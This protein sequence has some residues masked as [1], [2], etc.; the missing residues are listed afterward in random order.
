MKI[1]QIIN[2]LT[3]GGAQI[4]LLDL[5]VY[6]KKLGHDPVV[7]AFRDGPVGDKLRENGIETII[8]GE[9]GLDVI[10]LA[11]LCREIKN[12]A[13]DLIHS[14]LFRASLWARIAVKITGKRTLVT[15]IHG[16]E[17]DSYHFMEKKIYF[18]S[19]FV[20]FPSNY[21]ANWYKAEIVPLPS[22]KYGIIYPGTNVKAYPTQ[23][24]NSK[25][26][27]I[28]SLSRL[29][30]V[31]GIDTLLEAVHILALKLDNFEIIIGGD[32]KEKNRLEEMAQTLGISKLVTFLG[33]V[34]SPS[35]FLNEIDIFAAPSREEAFGINICEAMERGLPVIASRVGGIRETIHDGWDGI[36][37]NPNNSSELALKLE[38]LIKEPGLREKLGKFA[39]EKILSSF[40]REKALHEHL[41]VY[42]KLMTIAKMNIQVAISSCEIGGGENL[43]AT[44]SSDLKTR[45]WKINVLCGGER[46]AGLFRARGIN[47]EKRSLAVSG[48]FFA[49][50]LLASAK[51][52][53]SQIIYVH[54][55]K[56]ALYASKLAFIHGLP[57]AGHVHGQNRAVY[58][59]SC[60]VAFS[61][62]KAVTAS[63]IEQGIDP[64]KVKLIPNAIPSVEKLLR[65]E[66]T[67]PA[68]W[69]IAIIAKLHENKGHE[70][71]L[72]AI[73]N[74]ISKKQLSDIEILIFGEGPTKELLAERFSRKPFDR[75]F[76]FLGFQND[77]FSLYP[78]IHWV[79]LPSFSEG[80]PLSLLEAMRIGIP[81]IATN[82]GGIP[83]IIEN[84]FNGFLVKPNQPDELISAIKC[85][86]DYSL[87]KRFSQNA[88]EKFRKVN[89]FGK[90]V[91][92]IDFELRRLLN[93]SVFLKSSDEI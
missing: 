41:E 19:D 64:S 9:K 22:T 49:V 77:I 52:S 23:T 51:R 6:L 93:I 2:A 48:I 8:L 53:V 86:L 43:A 30:P 50:G 14:H 79:L 42:S 29:H 76:K 61:V 39:R 7:A 74:A 1:L 36:L 21:L 20:I 71:A 44:I 17:T 62:S 63:L 38:L 24:K 92:D 78:D 83:E 75:I 4:L 65:K 67:S 66:M 16:P 60:D 81:A 3:M 33:S 82:V 70:W 34:S 87:W 32:G 73:E 28:G 12:F 15:S 57:V 45:G 80:I 85:A 72:S 46:T 10:G 35:D 47:V 13:P 88:L 40:P 18:L 90:L 11:R 59:N 5:C 84:N 37:I 89:N 27:R 91:G 55:N 56:A 31:K 54:L 25:K 69:K 58:Y 26:I 68:V